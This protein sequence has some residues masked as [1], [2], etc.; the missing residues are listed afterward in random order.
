MSWKLC[1][2]LFL[3]SAVLP[4]YC[5]PF[6]D[7]IP[8]F[9]DHHLI[10]PLYDPVDDITPVLNMGQ[11]YLHDDL[12]HHI[13]PVSPI[14]DQG[15]GQVPQQAHVTLEINVNHRQKDS[16][17]DEND[18]ED[19]DDEKDDDDNDNK[20]EKKEESEETQI[21]EPQK[22]ESGA[23]DEQDSEEQESK[24]EEDSGMDEEEDKEAEEPE[25]DEEPEE[26]KTPEA[27][28]EDEGLKRRRR[29]M[30]SIIS[31]PFSLFGGLMSSGARGVQDM[32]SG[33]GGDADEFT[34]IDDVDSM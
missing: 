31:Q 7:H 24:S 12:L 6:D 20:K 34:I 14:V 13:A 11:D 23:E 8:F 26:E 30:P 10:D 2:T 3:V 16:H 4:V 19:M 28:P 22:D 32:I 29:Q 1:L 5:L 27:L 33:F 25:S 9:D 21:P 17:D 18:I 15:F